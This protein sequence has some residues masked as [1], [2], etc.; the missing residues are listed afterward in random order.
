MNVQ[1]DDIGKYQDIINLPHHVSSKHLA[2]SLE[3]RAAQF[4]PFA[5]LTGY[6]D[7]V[8]ETARITDR[9]LDLDESTKTILDEKLQ[10][11]SDRLD[12]HIEVVFTHFVTDNKKDGGQYVTSSGYVKKIDGYNYNIELEDKT[13]ISIENIIDIESHLFLKSYM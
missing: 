10:I 8:I 2:M 11:I 1:E 3:N 7:A 6:D 5:A 12:E 9:K 13:I 4:A